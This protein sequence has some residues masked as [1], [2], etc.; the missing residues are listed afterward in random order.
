[1]PVSTASTSTGPD[2]A[3][4]DEAEAEAALEADP[5]DGDELALEAA[6]PPGADELPPAAEVLAE[7]GPAPKILLIIEPKMLMDSSRDG[8]ARKGPRAHI[9][10]ANAPASRTFKL[11]GRI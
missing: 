2:E 6:C 4:L 7:A 10:V 3:E 1:M 9:A 5:A 11:Q 8:D